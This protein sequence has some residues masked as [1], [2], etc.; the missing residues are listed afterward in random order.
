MDA[1][2]YFRLAILEKEGAIREDI[3]AGG[4]PGQTQS[5]GDGL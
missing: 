4:L 1:S 3:R 2:L 5:P